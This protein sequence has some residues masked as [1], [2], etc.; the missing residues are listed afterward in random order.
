MIKLLEAEV[1]PTPTGVKLLLLPPPNRPPLLPPLA[2]GSADHSTYPGPLS[3]ESAVAP[4]E[5]GVEIAVML[6]AAAVTAVLAVPASE[7]VK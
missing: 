7:A 4:A 1:G 3:E 5:P 2:S 6:E